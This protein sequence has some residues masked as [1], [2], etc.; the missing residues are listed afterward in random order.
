MILH[1]LLKTSVKLKFV[2]KISA[3]PSLLLNLS[4]QTLNA[5]VP[6]TKSMNFSPSEIFL[7]FVPDSTGEAIYNAAS[8][9]AK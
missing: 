4:P 1:H 6:S 9:V 8:C 5:G 7:N 3:Q 2:Q